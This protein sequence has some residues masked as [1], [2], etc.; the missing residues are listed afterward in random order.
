MSFLKCQIYWLWPLESLV[1]LSVSYNNFS[2]I[3]QFSFQYFCLISR[4]YILETLLGLQKIWEETRE[5]FHTLSAHTTPP[6]R[7]HPSPGGTFVI[8]N[9]PKSIVCV[10]VTLG[11]YIPWVWTK[12]KGHVSYHCSFIQTSSTALKTLCALTVHPP[13]NDPWQP[14]I[15]LLNA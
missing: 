2:K 13:L 5:V 14:L 15:S 3:P 1:T 7:Q 10:R 8:I 9:Y 11:M 12:E 4:L 6:A